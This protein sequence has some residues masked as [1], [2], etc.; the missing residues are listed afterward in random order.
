MKYLFFVIILFS[1]CLINAQE[2][3]YFSQG[4]QA[5]KSYTDYKREYLVSEDSII[6]KDY[7]GDILHS[8]GIFYGFDSLNNLDAF[9][10]YYR[11]RMY[12]KK[13]NLILENRKALV[14][15]YKNVDTLDRKLLYRNDTI[16]HLQVWNKAGEKILVDGNGK[17]EQINS[18]G[19]ER[20]VIEYQD[21]LLVLDIGIRLNEKDTIY[22]LTDKAAYPE[23][24]IAKF[25]RQLTG[26]L[27]YPEKAL[28]RGLEAN[29]M[30]QF[31]V[32]V[33]GKLTDFKALT[34]YGHSFE[35]D[36]IEKLSKLPPW[37]PAIFNEKPVK[38]K[39]RLPVT[40]RL[41]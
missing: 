30:V 12:D 2:R 41:N 10:K 36:T 15:F 3:R 11:N 27:K 38:T 7:I 40:F 25:Y 5:Q 19:T 39:F 37:T 26:H 4:F 22:Y 20:N 33:D 32:D 18:Q 1:S 8:E 24:G 28:Q 9:F 29:I 34:S 16:Y 6:T 23:N 31:M 21:S 14:T 13:R 35:A 17:Y